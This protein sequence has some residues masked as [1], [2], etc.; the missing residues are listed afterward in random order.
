MTAMDPAIGVPTCPRCR[1]AMGARE[2][3]F[4]A[5]FGGSRHGVLEWYCPAQGCDFN[6][7]ARAT[8]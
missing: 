5:R 6:D 8:A 3:P 1:A 2:A 4:G 7:G